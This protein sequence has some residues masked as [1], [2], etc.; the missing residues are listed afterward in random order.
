MFGKKCTT[1]DKK[2]GGIFEGKNFGSSRRVLC[3]TCAEREKREKEQ[4]EKEKL[5][6]ER[7][8]RGQRY[9]EQ[10]ERELRAREQ[11]YKEQLE[12]DQRDEALIALNRRDPLTDTLPG[13]SASAVLFQLPTSLPP[14]PSSNKITPF[15]I[16]CV[17]FFLPISAAPGLSR[18]L[19]TRIMDKC[20]KA[21]W[22]KVSEQ[23]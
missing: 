4:R 6:K 5:E 7:R 22:I 11:R 10:H 16:S 8:E 20:P 19:S 1:C 23:F 13:P 14:P 17:L 12:R 2:V 3:E 9:M 18:R 21:F 15:R